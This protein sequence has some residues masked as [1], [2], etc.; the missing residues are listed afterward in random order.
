MKAM[1]AALAMTVALAMTGKARADALLPD[2]SVTGS[3]A[4]VSLI[5]QAAES[6]IRSTQLVEVGDRL[7]LRGR[8]EPANRS[9]VPR[10]LLRHIEV[11]SAS[12]GHEESHLLAVIPLRARQQFFTVRLNDGRETAGRTR[13]QLRY[14]KGVKLERG[15]G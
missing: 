13:L 6:Y 7:V 15:S 5:G 1:T 2:G 4:S 12:A 9:H 10:R 3:S 8:V 14:V 11:W